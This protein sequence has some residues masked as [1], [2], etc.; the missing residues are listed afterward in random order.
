MTQSATSLADNHRSQIT[1]TL[2]LIRVPTPP[3][4]PST[5][6]AHFTHGRGSLCIWGIG[7]ASKA[8]LCAGIRCPNSRQAYPSPRSNASE[9]CTGKPNWRSGGCVMSTRP[10]SNFCGFRYAVRYFSALHRRFSTKTASNRAV[11]DATGGSCPSHPA[12][13][14]A[15]PSYLCRRPFPTVTACRERRGGRRAVRGARCVLS[16]AGRR[17]W[18]RQGGDVQGVG[19]V[20]GRGLPQ[21]RIDVLDR[22]AGAATRARDH[23]R[24]HRS[25]DAVKPEKAPEF[26]HPFQRSLPRSHLFGE[27]DSVPST[28]SWPLPA[29]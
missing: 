11:F 7:A 4:P 19:P 6:L 17:R 5:P 18:Q 10:G 22:A 9:K 12:G 21:V 8:E 15:R 27:D 14:T 24:P 28:K 29:S 16:E 2:F 3:P 26:L 20:E 13:L 25:N 23:H 1:T